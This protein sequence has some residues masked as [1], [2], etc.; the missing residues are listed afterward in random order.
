MKRNL[1]RYSVNFIH[2]KLSSGA[3]VFLF[4]RKGM[5]IYLRASFFAGSRFD[6]LSGTSHYLEHMLLAGTKKFPSKNLIAEHIQRVGGDFGGAT[7][8]TLMHL[9]I[10]VPEAS[11][12]DIGIEVLREC[13]TNSIFD[14]KIIEKERGAIVSEIGAKHSNPKEYLGEVQRN[15]LLQGTLAGRS[16]LG[17]EK[18]VR[19]IGKEDLIKF[20]EKFFNSGRV[21]FIASGDIKMEVLMEGLESLNLRSEKK[22]L[23]QEKLP[24]ISERKIE[25]E[26]YT[27]SNHLHA[28]FACRTQIENYKEYCA[29]RVLSNV[30][31]VGRGSRLVSR[32]RYENGLVYTVFTFVF[33]FVDWGSFGIKLSC[34]KDNFEKI[35]EIV[36]KEFETLRKDN[37]SQNELDDAKSRISKGSYRHFQTSESWVDFHEVEALLAPDELHTLEDY[38]ETINNLNLGDIEKVI[39]KYLSPDNFFFAIC[40]DY[41]VK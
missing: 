14:E 25:I 30:L 18:S 3:D 9:N 35:K 37:I 21:A 28:S 2:N 7:N 34:D 11:D 40:G 27:N 4:Q 19:K 10:E 6:E 13:L 16:T 24:I 32:L 36:F 1:E 8:H 22:V 31:G 38:I 39:D 5:P 29:L 20:K 41:E 17:D 23:P 26:K 33:E 15:L 12:F